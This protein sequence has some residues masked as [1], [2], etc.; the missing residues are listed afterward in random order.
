[1]RV[2]V[3]PDKTNP[4]PVLDSNAVLPGSIALERFEAVARR[5]TKLLQSPR[6]VKIKKLAARHPL[7]RPEPRHVPILEERLGVTASKRA[8]QD[9]V[10]DVRGIPSSGTVGL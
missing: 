10:Y 7:D 8:D 1:M 3:P 4:P 2:D 9:P 6:R 5:N